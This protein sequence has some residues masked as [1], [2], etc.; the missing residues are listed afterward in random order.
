MADV[1][2]TGF[3]LILL[4]PAVGSFL[5]VLV[6]RLPAG[7]SVLT[8]SACEVCSQRLPWHNLIPIV[9]ALALRHRCSLCGAAFPGHLLRIEIAAILVAFAGVFAGET[10]THMWC[11]ALVFWCLIALFYIDLLHFRLPDALTAALFVAA[12]LSAWADP[13]GNITEAVLSGLGAAAFFAALRWAYRLI[14][15]REGM[16]LGDVKLMLGIGT[17]LGWQTLPLTIL[18]AA[19]LAVA[20]ILVEALRSRRPPNPTEAVPFGTYLAGATLLMGLF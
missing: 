2:S 1:P 17:F 16:G 15:K 3:L 11:V 9:S 18:V 12:A 7:R 6:S 10:A 5:G 13:A 4:S 8:P 20:S 14:R 19:G